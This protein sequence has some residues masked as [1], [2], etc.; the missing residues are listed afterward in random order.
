MQ[1]FETAIPDTLNEQI[2]E[3]SERLKVSK[4]DFAREALSFLYTALTESLR[5]RR[6]AILDPSTNES[7]VT[8]ALPLLMQAEWIARRETIKVNA[9]EAKTI[10]ELNARPAVSNPALRKAAARRQRSRVE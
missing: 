10:A 4:G 3:L 8:F 7:V 5:G 2:V 1:R 9:T 6:V